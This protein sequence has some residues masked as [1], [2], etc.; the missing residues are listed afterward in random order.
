MEIK[1][2]TNNDDWERLIVDDEIFA[3][4]H[5]IPQNVWIELIG[6]ISRN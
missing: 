4:G 3:E 5:S 6:M 2:Q 1:L